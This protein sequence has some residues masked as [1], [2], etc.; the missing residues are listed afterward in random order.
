MADLTLQTLVD[1]DVVSAA[2]ADDAGFGAG[3][4]ATVED[5]LLAVF[6]SCCAELAAHGYAHVARTYDCT[7]QEYVRQHVQ[8]GDAGASSRAAVVAAVL[9][10][11]LGT[12]PSA[13][14]NRVLLAE[15]LIFLAL[16]TGDCF[17][18]EGGFDQ[19]QNALYLQVSDAVRFDARVTRVVQTA[20]GV[21]VNYID[22]NGRV[23]SVAGSHAVVTVPVPALVDPSAANHCTIVPP[24]PRK[25]NKRERERNREREIERERER[26]REREVKAR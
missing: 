26:E 12:A 17:E 13:P 3:R 10:V 5:M 23:H 8:S 19:L 9:D 2:A 1:M 22:L 15:F 24:L 4:Q 25:R 16:K 11:L 18:I 6:G 7:I 20:T 21:S 14:P